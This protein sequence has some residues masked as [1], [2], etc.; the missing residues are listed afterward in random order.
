MSADESGLR[1]FGRVSVARSVYE[2]Q[3]L[4]KATAMFIDSHRL[5]LPPVVYGTWAVW[6]EVAPW[7]IETVQGEGQ[8]LSKRRFHDGLHA[9]E[10]ILIS[11]VPLIVMCE[12]QDFSSQHARHDLTDCS[13]HLLLFETHR[14]GLGLSMRVADRV[15]FLLERALEG[16]ESCPCRDGCPSC[17]FL[18]I[19]GDDNAHVD[20]AAAVDIAKLLLM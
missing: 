7:V 10:H 8:H 16:M 14:G 6:I 15:R 20:K 9:L 1:A 5:A 2:Y 17:V 19:C 12:Q 4:E 18:S 3:R 13:D 11:L